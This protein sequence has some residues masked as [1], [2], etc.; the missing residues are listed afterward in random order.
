MTVLSDPVKNLA[1]IAD[2]DGSGY[3]EVWT[4]IRDGGADG[5]LTDTP[6][7]TPIT[8]TGI[9]TPDLIPGPAYY[10]LK[11]GALRQS[12]EGRCIIPTSGPARV[13]DVI[14]AS[15]LVPE[16]TPAELVV[17]AV[18]A[19]L[20]ANPPSVEG[21]LTED[22]ANALYAPQSV[23][24]VAVAAAADAA[25]RATPAQVTNAV[26][27]KLDKT[28]AAST[29]IANSS[30]AAEQIRTADATAMRPWRA[31]LAARDYAPARVLFL[32]DSRTEGE[33]ATV[34]ARRWQDR[35]AAILRDRFRVT[36]GNPAYAPRNYL[37]VK[38]ISPTMLA[39]TQWTAP[40]GGTAPNNFGLGTRV[41]TL[42]VGNSTTLTFTG[43]SA[44]LAYVRNAAAA[45]F[46]YAVDGGSA[47]SVNAGGG[48]LD[49]Q[50]VAINGL[51]AG[52]HTIVV[53]GET[54]TTY[55]AGAYVY[56][57]EETKGIQFFDAGHHGVTSSSILGSGVSHFTNGIKPTD[58]HLVVVGIGT[59]DYGNQVNPA[60]YKTNMQTVLAA[61]RSACTLPPTVVIV[62]DSARA[63]VASP[64]YQ[65]PEYVAKL[66]E[67]VAE[68]PTTTTL[69]D[70][71][72]RMPPL[73]DNS[74]NLYADSLHENDRGHALRA[75][76]VA[77]FLSPS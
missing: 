30:L 11:L 15:I 76:V 51:S 73:T 38:Y 9:E 63:G 24:A 64:T 54:G 39:S 75:D 19:Y 52:S 48:L 47:V 67:L 17:Q 16:D 71:S 10:R 49:G 26:A 46:T 20:L 56:N 31:A 53:T 60:T 27:P 69:M 12:I 40:S 36:G 21:G 66:R 23:V 25:S 70:L 77:G 32:G 59:N 55:F 74:L 68:A 29:Y 5:I 44:K 41:V 42:G 4:S 8:A 58:P 13:M 62:A 7:H 45:S 35:V 22:E 1:K 2:F 6:V 43:T 34:V 50:T 57:G 37:P 14:A 61:V 33:G 3:L 18:Q 65:W 72:L 28:E